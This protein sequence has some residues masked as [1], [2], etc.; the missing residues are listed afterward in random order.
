MTQIRRTPIFEK[1]VPTKPIHD[2]GKLMLAFTILW[3]YLS[4][5]QYVIIWAGD[6]AESVPW[7]VRRTSNGWL[8]IALTLMCCSFFAPFLSLLGRRPKRNL[9]Y[10]AGV[11]TWI[12]VMRF[13]DVSWII[14][15]E[16]HASP[17]EA[18]TTFTNYAAPLGL[19]G[20]FLAIWSFN[21]QRAPLLPLNDANMEILRL[22]AGG[23]H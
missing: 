17:L 21:M 19:F 6:L 14:L 4:Y 12:L 1:Y 22:H 7:Y 11:A 18:Y 10:L 5:G 3:T 23:H 20:I 8:Y 9:N 15:P 13:I 2:L 16:F